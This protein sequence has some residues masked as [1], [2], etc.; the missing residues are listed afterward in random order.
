MEEKY[1]HQFSAGH[2]SIPGGFALLKPLIWVLRLAWEH[3]CSAKLL[4]ISSITEEKYFRQFSVDYS[5]IP[6]GFAH[7][8]RQQ[9]QI[10]HYRGD[11]VV[12]TGANLSPPRGFGSDNGS[13]SISVSTNGIW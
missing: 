12:T 4:F 2:S 11:F 1:S 13:R 10:C 8:R 9:R 5:S 6:D 3:N 7:L